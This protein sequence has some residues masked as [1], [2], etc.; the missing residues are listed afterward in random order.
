MSRLISDPRGVLAHLKD[1]AEEWGHR[2]IPARR[3]EEAGISRGWLIAGITVIGL[4]VLAAYYIG[5]DVKRY[6]KIRNM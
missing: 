5:P 1:D 2:M 4:G 6:M 3:N